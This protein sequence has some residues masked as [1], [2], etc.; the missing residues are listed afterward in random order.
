MS[1]NYNNFNRCSGWR[2]E[3]VRE[4]Y[5]ATAGGNFRKKPDTVKTE[6]VDGGF[7]NNFVQSI[8]WFNNR[9]LGESCRAAWNYTR[10]GYIPDRIVTSKKGYK[11]YVD[12]FKPID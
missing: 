3:H 10:A 2:F 1:Y 9:Y 7:Y 5:T 4:T 12:T 8:P 11:K 6:I